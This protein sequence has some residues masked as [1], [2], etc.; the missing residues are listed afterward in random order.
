MFNLRGADREIIMIKNIGDGGAVTRLIIEISPEK[1][2]RR[3]RRP[4]ERSIAF[5]AEIRECWPRRV[6]LVKY[7][8]TSE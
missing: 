6:T 5:R 2:G 7:Y 1:A 3:A 8:L 4:V